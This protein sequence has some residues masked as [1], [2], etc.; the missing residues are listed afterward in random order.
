MKAFE[1]QKSLKLLDHATTID[2]NFALAYLYKG[3][4]S[5][6]VNKLSANIES[7]LF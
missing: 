4:V 3:L 7:I 6:S 1:F 2:T 5:G